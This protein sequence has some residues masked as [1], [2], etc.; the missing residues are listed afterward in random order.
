MKKT[1]VIKAR[2][3]MYVK[4]T[5]I[6]CVVFSGTAG[7]ITGALIFLFKLCAS[8]L[9]NISKTAYDFVH[10]HPIYVPLLLVLLA[11]IAVLAALLLKWEPSCKGGGIPTSIA[12]LR[13][14]ISFNW[15]KN[16][17]TLFASAM[18]TYLGGVPLGNEGP[19][20]QMGTAAG[21][22]VISL[23]GKKHQAW[24]RYVMTGGA[25]AGF[26][27]A[28]GA[29]ISGMLFSLEEAH[30]RFSPMIFMTSAIAVIAGNLTMEYLCELFDVDYFMFTLIPY[31]S[32]P[33][34][35]IWSALIIGAACAAVA[36]IFTKQYRRLFDLFANKLAKVPLTVKFIVT[37]VTVGIAG[38]TGIEFLGS[39]HDV[40]ELVLEGQGIWYMLLLFLCVRAILLIVANNAGVT[41]GL[42]VPSLAFGALIG[43][44]CGKAMVFVGALPSEYY[45]V[46]LIVGMSSY[47][48]ASSR[49][50]LTAIVF[51]IE[52]LCGYTNVLP[53]A[54]GAVLA[55]AIIETLGV[56]AF[57]EVVIETK[58]ESS[59]RGKNATMVKTALTV[60]NG[61]FIVDK[62]IRDILWPPSCVVTSVEKH[63]KTHG[64][65][66]AEGDVLHVQY[67]TYDNQTTLRLLE[68]LVGEQPFEVHVETESQK[69]NNNDIIPD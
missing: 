50:P 11:A 41:G 34:R 66:T 37:F 12:I 13:G 22:G 26:A 19:S 58:V 63:S 28:T 43:A 2:G 32:L 59:N 46:M 36:V 10:A 23:F 48:S 20:V 39:G 4:R 61:S 56:S 9:I 47:L 68:A 69:N 7:V 62:E 6:P 25:C 44:L 64:S 54:A 51:A 67:M 42:F 18:L 60:Q 17:V 15:L 30:R 55:Y 45:S 57:S 33:L 5:L 16:I 38:V 35:F 27:A 1:K 40:I 29:P 8:F 21:R 14:L 31:E 52:A 65:F 3:L 24:D 49:T 53:I